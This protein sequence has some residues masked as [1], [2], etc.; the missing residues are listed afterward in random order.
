[1]PKVEKRKEGRSVGSRDGKLS[2]R[3]AS[4]S[5]VPRRHLDASISGGSG[6][7]VVRVG[8]EKCVFGMAVDE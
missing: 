3:E 2:R 7:G 4:V 8:R 5:G 6:G 1:M